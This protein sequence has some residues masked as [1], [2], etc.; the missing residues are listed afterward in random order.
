MEY[1]IA[2]VAFVERIQIARD[3]DSFRLLRE[4]QVRSSL[5][6]TRSLPL[7]FGGLRRAGFAGRWL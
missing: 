3:E 5:A 7:F 1:F 2:G 4:L 6:A